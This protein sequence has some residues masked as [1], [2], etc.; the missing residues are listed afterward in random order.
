LL[1]LEMYLLGKSLEARFLSEKVN[2]C[3]VLL[4]I[5][6]FSTRRGCTI[7]HSY[8]LCVTVLRFFFSLTKYFVIL[9]YI[10]AMSNSFNLLPLW[11]RFSIFHKRLLKTTSVSFCMCELSTHIFCPFLY[12]VISRFLPKFQVFLYIT[13]MIC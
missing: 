1:L 4:N 9:F 2:T 8:Q 10:L 3:M 13:V 6:K 12:R 11:K 5:I 7:S